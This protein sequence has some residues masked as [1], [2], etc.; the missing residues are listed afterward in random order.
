MKLFRCEV[1][2]LHL[3]PWQIQQ[4][5]GERQ[6]TKRHI[7]L[8]R[9]VKVINKKT[10]DG[11]IETDPADT[12]AKSVYDAINGK[13]LVGIAMCKFGVNPAVIVVYD[14]T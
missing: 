1:E 7:E 14:D 5:N 4:G 3:S 8:T 11:N 2:T 6:V 9:H 10:F 12:L 13:T